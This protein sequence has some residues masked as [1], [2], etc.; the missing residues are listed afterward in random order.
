M[1]MTG[2]K[3]GL[4]VPSANRAKSDAT[5]RERTEENLLEKNNFIRHVIE[6]SPVVLIVYDLA[7]EHHAYFSN[8]AFKVYGYTGDEMARMQDPFAALMEPEDIP[9]IRENVKRLK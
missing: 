7:A 1:K 9:R 2:K 6:L 8:D 4:P 3:T 5:V